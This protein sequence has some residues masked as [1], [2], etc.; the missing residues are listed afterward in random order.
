MSLPSIAKCCDEIVEDPSLLWLFPVDVNLRTL[1]LGCSPI[2]NHIGEAFCPLSIPCN[3]GESWGGSYHQHWPK[4]KLGSHPYD[5]LSH[6]WGQRRKPW[7]GDHF[8]PPWSSQD[9]GI[10]CTL[11]PT[12]TWL[13]GTKC[14]SSE[15]VH[16][17]SLYPLRVLLC[18]LSRH[19]HSLWGHFIHPIPTGSAMSMHATPLLWHWGG[20]VSGRG[21]GGVESVS[22]LLRGSVA[23]LRRGTLP[24]QPNFTVSPFVSPP[25]PS[26]REYPDEGRIGL[27][28]SPQAFTRYQSG[29][30]SAAMWAGQ[31]SRGVVQKIQ[32]FRGPNWPGGMRDS[33]H[34]WLKGQMPPFK[35]SFPGQAWLTWSSC[36]PGASPPWIPFATWVK[37]LPPPCNRM[38]ISQLPPLYLGQRAHWLQT[39]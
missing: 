5:N 27:S 21:G 30:S 39:P 4:D 29:Q 10:Q 7:H 11:C 12:S 14:G 1:T 36:C 16:Q 32:L 34:R 26:R 23:K 18:P 19:K 24:L 35:R 28:P 20:P 22:P 13:T 9:G 17:H 38:R 2:Q 33:E 6:R 8:L 31:G 37:H 3:V 25:C 15:E